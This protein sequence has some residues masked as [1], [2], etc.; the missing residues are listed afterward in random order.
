MR[1]ALMRAA[2]MR[3][4]LMRYG[5]AALMRAALMRAALMRA[6]LMR[7]GGA[8]LMRRG[9]WPGT[10]AA[11]RLQERTRGSVLAHKVLVVAPVQVVA[12]EDEEVLD[13]VSHSV[14]KQP[15]VLAHRIRRACTRMMVRASMVRAAAP[16]AWPERGRSIGTRDGASLSV[17]LLPPVHAHE[18]SHLPG[19]AWLPR[20]GHELPNRLCSR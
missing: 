5:G 2:L 19:L 11:S 9:Q 8:A 6:A 15:H 17:T 16:Q 10:K 4:A 3:A 20:E 7:C 14:L 1:A 12:R 13:A 18:G